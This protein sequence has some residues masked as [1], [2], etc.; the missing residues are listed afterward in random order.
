MGISIAL[1]KT[2]EQILSV[3]YESCSNEGLKDADNKK[4]LQ[5]SQQENRRYYSHT[6]G[7]ITRNFSIAL[8][9]FYSFLPQ[10][11]YHTIGRCTS[12]L[13]SLRNS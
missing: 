11:N 4:S 3:M 10:R 12:C 9:N 13:S 7:N 2:K 6:E 1:K 5:R 8:K